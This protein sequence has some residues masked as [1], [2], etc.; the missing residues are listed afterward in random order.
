MRS[1][2]LDECS[3]ARHRRGP[4]WTMPCLAAFA[5]QTNGARSIGPDIEIAN[6]RGGG[7]AG[8]GPGVVEEQEAVITPAVLDG[9]SF[10]L[11]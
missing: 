1:G 5:D 8:A 3:E 9:T 7:L 2:P 4:Q 6:R 10:V 11:Q